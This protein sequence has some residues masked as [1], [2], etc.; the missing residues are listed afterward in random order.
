MLLPTLLLVSCEN[1][2]SKK[3]LCEKLFSYYE[4]NAE[5]SLCDGA[6]EV[7]SGELSV[8]KDEMIRMEFASP[9]ELS[10]VC[11]ESDEFSQ[12]DIITFS[13]YG[14][15]IPLPD[16]LLS[17]LNLMFSIFS[18]NIPEKI[19]A[20]DSK[21]FE[22]CDEGEKAFLKCSFTDGD[23][24]YSVLF[25]KD[26]GVPAEFTAE[27]GGIAFTATITEFRQLPN[28]NEG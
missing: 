22:R 2:T 23:T 4:L 7:F 5:Y 17:K 13:Y 14:I 15:R 27:K 18:D 25:E 16:R 24:A 10:G 28:I 6:N 12:P 26:S 20:L 19:S 21:G 3:E 11:V 1:N 9:D 8:K